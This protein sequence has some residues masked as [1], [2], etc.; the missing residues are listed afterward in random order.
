MANRWALAALLLM[1]AGLAARE[2]KAGDDLALVP[3]AARAVISTRVADTWNTDL[4]RALRKAMPKEMKLFDEELKKRWGAAPADIE[5]VTV[6]VTGI[7]RTPELAMIVKAKKKLDGKAVLDANLPGAKA[8]KVGDVEL[9][10]TE[11]GAAFVK[12]ETVLV[13]GVPSVV[14][15][16][17]EGKE[18]RSEGLSSALKRIAAGKD[19]TVGY[20]DGRLIPDDVKRNLPGPL[21]LLKPLL[22][23]K[24]AVVWG[25][26]GLTM[27]M[28]ARLT[29]AGE[30]E[31]KKAEKTLNALK[32]LGTAT[33]SNLADQWKKGPKDL[34]EMVEFLT[35]AEKAL[36]KATLKRS[37]AAVEAELSIT[38]P[39]KKTVAEL[40]RA[41]EKV[42]LAAGRMQSANNLKQMGVALHNYNNAHKH[43]PA[44]AIYS[45]DGKA[46]LSWRVEILP[47]VGEDALYKKF[48]LNE[49]W[50]SPHNKKLIPLMPKL[51]KPVKGKATEPNGTFYQVFFGKGAMFEGKRGVKPVDVTDGLSNTIMV[52]EAGKDVVW[53]KP[54]DVP[55]DADKKLPKLGAM[56]E[57][58]FHALLADGSVRFIARSIEPKTLKA[59][60]TRAGD[61]VIS[62]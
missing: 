49:P 1:S 48:K 47:Y 39:E 31:A 23:V 60:I 42:H 50:D 35:L 9:F 13:M 25:N 20:L 21:A 22:E 56:F 32:A 53:T 3:G 41:V 58:G 24:E 7:G 54:D 17:M 61:E 45:K 28:S 37:G 40:V 30:D 14:K 8:K 4:S 19:H 15:A 16:I 12:G 33:L 51:Y 11:R 10:Q 2:E 44:N 43:F 27:K 46:L 6:V 52:V 62:D 57:A 34:A 5:R 59:L 18:K 26:Q 38:L 29:F 55:F 36:D